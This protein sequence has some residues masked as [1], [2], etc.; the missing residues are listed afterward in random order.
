MHSPVRT[1]R[2]LLLLVSMTVA[3]GCSEDPAMP[4]DT[5]VAALSFDGVDDYVTVTDAPALDITG[6]ITLSAWFYFTGN[7]SGEP[8]LIQKDGPGSWGRYGLW[9]FGSRIDFCIFIDGGAQSCV[10]SV[11]DLTLNAWNHVAG[12][13]DGAE[14]RLYLNG[15]LDANT[16]LTGAIS[17][18]TEALYLGGDPT[19]SLFLPGQLHEVCVWN[20]ARAQASIMMDMD[21][22]AYDRFRNGTRR[23]L[24]DDGGYGPKRR[25]LYPQQ[26]R[27]RA[28]FQ[29]GGRCVGSNLGEHNLASLL[30]PGPRSGVTV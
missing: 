17:A 24:V 30:T 9:V 25:R 11:G 23:L 21:G 29:C 4:M 14:M 15:M 20:I 8:G 6:N 28:G 19:E 3:Q 18:S 1:I 7:V 16:A 26:S 27:W 12:V 22:H 13:Y 2:M 10:A 5:D